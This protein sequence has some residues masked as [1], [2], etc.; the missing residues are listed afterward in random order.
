MLTDISEE[1]LVVAV[2]KAKEDKVKPLIKMILCDATNLPFKSGLFDAVICYGSLHH[3]PDA[4]L[5]IKE[6]GRVCKDNGRWFSID[7]NASSVR[8]IFD[9]FMRMKKLYDEVAADDI[10]LDKKVL[11]SMLIDAKFEP[12]ISYSTYLLPHIMGIL[13]FKFGRFMLEATDIAFSNV[14]LLNSLGGVILA[15][16]EKNK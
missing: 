2:K 16:G 5:V 6:G 9:W 7:P 1:M 8:F 13:P 12:K 11:V 4:G 10:H 3:M 15:Y 14:P